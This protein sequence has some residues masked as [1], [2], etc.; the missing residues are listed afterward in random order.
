VC[1]NDSF[2]FHEANRRRHLY[3]SQGASPRQGAYLLPL[4]A[5]RY[6]PAS[7]LAVP[8]QLNLRL[9]V[10]RPLRPS[11][12]RNER[13]F[14]IFTMYFAKAFDFVYFDTK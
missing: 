3:G 5:F 9:T 4:A 1:A 8:P 14:A 11:L 6:M 10:S 2:R 12:A 13:F 7:L